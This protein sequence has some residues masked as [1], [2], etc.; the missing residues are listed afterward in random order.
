M[1]RFYVL[2]ATLLALNISIPPVMYAQEGEVDGDPI[3][4]AEDPDAIVIRDT[5]LAAVVRSTL[6]LAED[7][8]LTAADML[9][10]KSLE[11]KEA[12]ISDL[13]GLEHATNLT[14]LN[15]YGN[16]LTNISPLSRLESLISLDLG[17]NTITDIEPLKALTA[18]T[19]LY[20]D[21][22]QLTDLRPL[23]SLTD[24]SILHLSRTGISD[25]SAL[26][27]LT[28]LTQ[29]YLTGNAISD[30]SALSGLTE[31]GWLFL[32]QNQISNVSPLAGIEA[33]KVL[34]LLGNPVSNPSV[35]YGLTQRNL[36]D[37][38]IEI[39]P[40]PAD[41]EPPSVSIAVPSDPQNSAFDV[42]ITFSE[43][44]SNFEQADVTLSGTATASITGWST[45]DDT[46]FTATITPTT[47]GEVGV[48]VIADLAMD[49]ASNNNTASE[50]QTVTV[51]ITP[52]EVSISVPADVQNSAFDVVITFT[53]KVSGFEQSDV[54]LS[55]TAVASITGWSTTDDTIFTATITP[56]TSGEVGV[57]VI[58]D[59]AMDAASNNNTASEPQTVTVDM[60]SPEVSISVPGGVQNSEFNVVITFTEVVSDFEP[61]DVTLSGTATASITG[62]STT[63]DTVF[64][65]TITPTTSGEVGVSVIADLAMDAANNNNTASESQTVTVDITPPEVSISVPG[66]VQNS[67]FDVV[68]TFTEKVS[69]FEQSDVTLSGT[70]VA[71]I[72]GWSTTDDTIFTATITP[73]TSGEVVVSVIADLAMD[74]ANNNNTASE[75]QTVTVDMMPPEVSI[76]VP[77]GVQN[78]EFNVVI[79]FTEPVSGFDQTDV[80]FSGKATVS[81]TGWSTSDDTAFTARITPTTSGDVVLRVRADAA[82]DAAGNSNT[83]SDS[84]TVTVDIDAPSVSISVPDGVQNGAF[85]VVITFTEVVSDFDEADVTLSGTATASITGWSV[86]GDTVFTATLTPTTSGEVVVSVIADVA[87][88]AAS[89]NNTASEPQTVTVDMMPPE[90]SISVPA[91]VQN[92]AFDVVI[93]FTQKVS[94]FEQSDFTLSGTAVASITAWST[95]DDT[96][97]TA[98]ITPTTSG[99][100]TL[101]IVEGAVTDTAGNPNVLS[102]A[103]VSITMD[104]SD[105]PASVFVSVCDRT[106]QVRDTIVAAL[107]NVS[108]CA[109]V[110]AAD[111][112][113]I[114]DLTLI[115]QNI[116]ALKA[117]DFNGLTALETLYLNKN[118]LISLPDGIFDGLT[119]LETLHLNNNGLTSLP[120]GIFD[121]LTALET[122]WLVGNDLRSLPDGIF[123]DLTALEALHLRSNGLSSLPDGIF[124]DL[125]ALEW[126]YLSGNSLSSLPAGIFD[127]LTALEYLNLQDNG[128]SSLPAGIFDDLTAL[129]TISLSNYGLSS[130][131]ADIFD[132]LTALERLYLSGNTLS[133]L[134]AGIFDD[135]T[136]L[137]ELKLSYNTLSS[138]PAG[139]FGKLTALESSST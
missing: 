36:I 80:T 75:P 24:L 83:A 129:E 118:N 111:L 89:N 131:P 128:L 45:T 72:T 33:L 1:K 95:T 71:S 124:D 15:L 53:E 18:L 7:A 63:D 12:E 65:A 10:L 121:G 58:A 86:T 26:E 47:S 16:Q 3:G 109:D 98:T 137:E 41:T 97:F 38:D 5:N 60:M 17:K 91:D 23:S 21:R 123:D 100:L 112:A 139:I 42:T 106:P 14:T 4:A 88:D 113:S 13:S 94:G 117:D 46:V 50:P 122:L 73:T 135:L 34:R 37:V 59:L 77:G 114:T 81:I 31:M 9:N 8:P 11:A 79:T 120:D 20:L 115:S 127:D 125:T 61:A 39:P 48:S 64:T 69:G 66:G 55:G 67:A 104:V 54:T 134:P 138:L 43:A 102:T 19:A 133:S 2:F 44:V 70:A 119:A 82:T 93:T 107:P 132:D 84:E 78:S 27:G 74:A 35:L 130:L 87:M 126:L 25:L 56:T 96:I 85:D 110:T 105:D 52:P 40:P 51:D 29:L 49:A 101:S 68:I 99:T 90:V 30:I 92:S 108:D 57:S 136:A 76:S 28:T 116:T 62:W 32:A 22:N 103:E 6:G